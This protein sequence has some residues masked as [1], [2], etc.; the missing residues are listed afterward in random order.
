[1]FR[2]VNE[3]SQEGLSKS[4]GNPGVKTSSSSEIQYFAVGLG[5][6]VMRA[7]Q[8]K[9]HTQLLGGHCRFHVWLSQSKTSKSISTLC[10][11]I[12]GMCSCQFVDTVSCTTLLQPPLPQQ[13]PFQG[14]KGHCFWLKVPPLPSS[15]LLLISKSL[16]F[17]SPLFLTFLS[18]SVMKSPS[19]AQLH[20]ME[21]VSEPMPFYPLP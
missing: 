4:L 9:A 10:F 8:D 3:S 21:R 11:G 14:I 2:L 19:S 6:C 12:V 16:L 17:K 13:D 5:S 15:I 18:F 20:K 7:L 1:M